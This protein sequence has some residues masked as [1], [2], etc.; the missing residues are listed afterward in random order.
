MKPDPIAALAAEGITIPTGIEPATD[1]EPDC[2]ICARIL[3]IDDCP[4]T[5]PLCDQHRGEVWNRHAEVILRHIIPDEFHEAKPSLAHRSLQD[6]QPWHGG[7]YLFGPTGTGKSYDAAAM[8]KRAW[9]TW[10]KQNGKSPSAAWIVVP[11]FIERVLDSFGTNEKVDTKWRDADILVLDE[12]G[13]GDDRPFAIRK[14]YAVIERRSQRR[15]S[16]VTIVTSNADLDALQQHLGDDRIPS[17]LDGMCAQ[18][19]YEGMPDRRSGSS[20]KIGEN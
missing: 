19:S 4:P 13:M 17:R 8:V 16:Q 1:T 12:I 6:W 7:L 14:L 3:T 9:I 15:K 5:L 20:P 2:W 18:V 11:D 10:R